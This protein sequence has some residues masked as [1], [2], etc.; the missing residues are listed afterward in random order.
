LIF[1]RPDSTRW[2]FQPH[3]GDGNAE[4]SLIRAET[5]VDGSPSPIGTEDD[6]HLARAERDRQQ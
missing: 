6:S 3:C 1:L 2:R 4:F 5:Q